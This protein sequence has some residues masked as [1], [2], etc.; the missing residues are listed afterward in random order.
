MQWRVAR[1]GVVQQT[2]KERRGLTSTAI[3]RERHHVTEASVIADLQQT[4]V[5]FQRRVQRF[6][7]PGIR[8]HSLIPCLH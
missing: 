8:L 7:G 1:Q 4:L 2:A 5:G 3:G 6:S